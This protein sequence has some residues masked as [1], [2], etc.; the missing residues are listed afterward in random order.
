MTDKILLISER[1]KDRDSVEKEMVRNGFEVRWT[2]SIPDQEAIHAGDQFI[3]ILA[4]YDL[5]GNRAKDCIHRLQ[6][7]WSRSCVILYGDQIRS[8]DLSEML[9]SGVYGFIPKDL[10]SERIHDTLLAGLENRKAFMEIVAM[11][12][13]LKDINEQ[14]EKEK[15]SLRKKNQ[16]LS[17]INRL[18]REIAYDLN[19]EKILPR[20]LGSGLSEA[21]DPGLMGIL[22]RIGSEWN[23]ALHLAGKEMNKEILDEWKGYLLEKFLSLAGKDITGEKVALHLYSSDLK[24][25]SSGLSEFSPERSLSL[26][27]AGNPLGLLFILPKNGDPFDNDKRE[28]IYTMANL[29]AMSLANAQ[30]YYQ[31][32]LL[33]VKDGLTGV[34]NRQGFTEFIQREFQRARRYSKPL[35]LIMIDVDNFKS[36]NDAFGHQAGDYVLR[37]LGFCL[38]DALRKTDIVARYGGDE[39]ALILPETDAR[40]ASVLMN[41]VLSALG[42]HCFEWHGEKMEVEISYGTATAGDLKHH[43]NDTHLIQ[44]ADQR[45]Y[46]SKGSK[47]C[48]F[49]QNRRSRSL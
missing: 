42:N 13:A 31:L 38:K 20:V 33:T 1:E 4:D 17:F 5:L 39:F 43:E 19:W 44:L 12:E 47:I 36:I 21:V 28:L 48:T 15:E 24:V 25:S 26:S 35:A 11:M 8:E 34:F 32:K 14:I 6:K 49:S 7:Y 46:R 10:L 18:S 45:L 9:Q 37:E 22:Y 29:L 2:R 40:R 27:L 23:L 16:E 41:R 30:E 3:A